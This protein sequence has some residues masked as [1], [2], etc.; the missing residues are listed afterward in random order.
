MISAR[1][2][3]VEGRGQ[4]ALVV[5]ASALFS[6]LTMAGALPVTISQL[7]AREG[8]R[9]RDGL[10]P[11]VRPWS[12]WA[13][14]PS[15]AAGA[16]VGWVLRD[17]STAL[18][19][20]LGLATAAVTYQSIASGILGAALQGELASIRTVAVGALLLAAPF[21]AALVVGLLV[22]DVGDPVTIAWIY[23]VSG[24][25][26]WWL[27]LRLLKPGEGRET[28]LTTAEIGRTTRANYV[29]AVGTINTLGL[30]RN[31]V[32]IWMGTASLGLYVVGAAFSNLSTII[33]NGVAS[34]L[35]PRLA[36]TVDEPAA[37]RHLIRSWLTTT[38]VLVALLVGFLQ[39]VLEPV[40][41][42]A[43][44]REFAPA[45]EIARWLVLA[46][47]LLG[48]R[49]LPI[50]ILQ[51]RGRPGV[52][53]LIELGVTVAVVAG[54]AVASAVGDVVLVAIVMAAGGFVALALLMVGVVVCQPRRAPRHRAA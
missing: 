20:G 37:Q 54:I 44:G 52:A 50:C 40:I 30:D 17:E 32:G 28:T 43:F 41:V 25:F 53:S 38:A 2:L 35:L 47:G 9:A 16:Y 48:L 19:I 10:R 45:V 49:R 42:T 1:L 14:L 34:L 15:A 18:W 27:N 22:S 23:V 29:A 26:G 51:A 5:A 46:D 4:L 11:F 24:V 21:P 36:A 13:L 8:L 7:L 31:L 33:G 6:R 12:A 3:G 39:L